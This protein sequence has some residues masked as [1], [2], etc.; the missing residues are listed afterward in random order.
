MTA[1]GPLDRA[2]AA[3]VAAPEDEAARRAYLALLVGHEFL[4]ALKDE[5]AGATVE[6]ECV[7][8]D[9]TT[10]VIAHDGDARLTAGRKGAVARLAATGAEIARLIA[11]Q[12]LGLIVNPGAPEV[13]FVLDPDGVRWLAAEAGTRP[14]AN[15]HRLG[16]FGRPSGV[17]AQTLAALDARL[18]GAGGLV[19]RAAL[20]GARDAE[21]APTLVLA[22]A[23]VPVDAEAALAE[24]LGA[25]MRLAGAGGA[26]ADILFL[27]E[28]GPEFAAIAA[29]GL[30]F[31]PPAPT[32]PPPPGTAGPPR[33]RR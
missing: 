18:A 21:G 27:P 1:D 17:S 3:M 29:A 7:E 15:A 30:V 6:P 14:E 16:D 9:G 11:P 32:A 2:H 23:G 28:E 22:L 25:L 13:A 31:E 12:V 8:L 4:V 33:L 5:G 19:R 10:F 26:R 20:A 24:G